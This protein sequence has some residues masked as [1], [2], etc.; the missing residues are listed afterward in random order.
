MNILPS[1][2]HRVSR[3]S[4]FIG[5]LVKYYRVSGGPP[6]ALA[7]GSPLRGIVRSLADMHRESPHGSLSVRAV[8]DAGWPYE[9]VDAQVLTG[10]VYCAIAKLR[11]GGLRELLIRTDSGYQLDP[12]CCVIEDMPFAR[13]A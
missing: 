3:S 8:F 1:F 12:H 5:H 6:V 7:Q 10:R 2:E 9:R 4:L 11:R 13:A